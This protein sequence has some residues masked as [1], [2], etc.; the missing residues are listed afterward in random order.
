MGK[1]IMSNGGFV[2]NGLPALLIL[3]LHYVKEPGIEGSASTALFVVRVLRCVLESRFN[4]SAV[5]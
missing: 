3:S 5:A 4:E 1:T 2:L